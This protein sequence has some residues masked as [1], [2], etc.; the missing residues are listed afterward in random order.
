M[1]KMQ[2]VIPATRRAIEHLQAELN[3]HRLPWDQKKFGAAGQGALTIAV[4]ASVWIADGEGHMFKLIVLADVA[5]DKF[6]YML[7]SPGTSPSR[8]QELMVKHGFA[9]ADD[10][11]EHAAEWIEATTPRHHLT[12]W[13]AIER[14]CV[15]TMCPLS[16]AE[17]RGTVHYELL[18][19]GEGLPGV[20]VG[21]LPA[22]LT[23]HFFRDGAFSEA[24]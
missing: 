4:A 7:V 19:V 16:M 12:T 22:H 10:Q 21:M 23:R 5:R 1:K 9:L 18:G 17:R 24:A 2:D 3:T 13:E 20:A 15:E 6:D 11:R 8:L 14:A